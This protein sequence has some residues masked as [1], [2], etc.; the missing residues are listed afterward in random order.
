MEGYG[1]VKTASE[2]TSDRC[3]GGTL[4]GAVAA[5]MTVKSIEPTPPMQSELQNMERSIERLDSI[6]SR[7]AGRI[8]PVCHVE[9]PSPIGNAGAETRARA[10]SGLG[11]QIGSYADQIDGLSARMDGLLRR[12]EL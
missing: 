6:L 9:P 4:T 10:N 1:Y 2:F 8:E 11:S 7:L 12:C 3:N 5:Q